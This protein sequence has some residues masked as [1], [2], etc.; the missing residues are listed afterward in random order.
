MEKNQIQ[1][2]SIARG[3][4]VRGFRLFAA[5]QHKR[6][7]AVAI[8]MSL[9]IMLALP[10]TANATAHSLRPSSQLA[11]GKRYYAGKVLTFICISPSGTG[12]CAT[13]QNAASA[14]GSYLHATVNVETVAGGNGIPGMDAL[15]RAS[16]NGLTFGFINP[17]AVIPLQL[18]NAPGLNF[19]PVRLRF[20]GGT[21]AYSYVWV[22][23][24]SSPYSSWQ[25]VEK[26]SASGPVS[27][28]NVTTGA[29]ELFELGLNGTFKINANV[30]TG[31]ASTADMVQ[32]FI[33]GDGPIAEHSVSTWETEIQS[34][35]ARPILLNIRTKYIP[36]L[37][38]PLKNVPTVAEMAKKYLPKGKKAQEELAVLEDTFKMPL[39]LAMPTATSPDRVAALSAALKAAFTSSAINTDQL[40]LGQVPGWISGSVAKTTWLAISK[41]AALLT[42]FLPVG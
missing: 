17:G 7:V 21:P 16:S 23:S 18:S 10:I 3:Q 6:S 4:K 1:N 42:P 33:R 5:R 40:N 31:Y 12:T 30:I 13:A 9:M 20:L 38:A 2:A 29:G 19:N 41:Q 26:A 27:M 24:P 8:V 39:V 22:S 34:G 25:A 15:A 11:A 14:V 36:S 32:G 37:A 28:L 35:V